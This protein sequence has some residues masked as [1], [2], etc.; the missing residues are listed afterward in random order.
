MLVRGSLLHAGSVSVCG[1][2]RPPGWQ[3]CAP[4]ALPN[5]ICLCHGRLCL[6]VVADLLP[7]GEQPASSVEGSTSAAFGPH[8]PSNRRAVRG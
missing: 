3:L 4:A 8:L 6:Q 7:K 2:I 1:W 5:C